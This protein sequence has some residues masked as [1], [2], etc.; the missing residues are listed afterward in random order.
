MAWIEL[1]PFEIGRTFR[2]P[3]WALIA[4]PLGDILIHPKFKHDADSVVFNIK[5]R[6]E[7]IY[8]HIIPATHDFGW[9]YQCLA[10][11]ELLSKAGWDYIYYWLSKH[12]NRRARRAV[13]PIRY[14][15]VRTKPARMVWNATPEPTPIPKQYRKWYGTSQEAWALR[16]KLP[17]I[18]VDSSTKRLCLMPPILGPAPNELV[19]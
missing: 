2:M 5:E 8:D 15:G 13:A 4:G 7:G 17:R 10:T 16:G 6:T 9:E 11:G 1:N 14:W 19:I 18:A 3:D 12:S